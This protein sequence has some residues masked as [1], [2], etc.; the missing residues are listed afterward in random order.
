MTRVNQ[1]PLTAGWDHNILTMTNVSVE[2]SR[3]GAGK[4]KCCAV[5]SVTHVELV[6]IWVPE[7]TIRRVGVVCR[8]SEFYNKKLSL[9]YFIKRR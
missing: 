8:A 7:R 1:L 2:Y 9:L 5:C 6:W 4:H 3:R